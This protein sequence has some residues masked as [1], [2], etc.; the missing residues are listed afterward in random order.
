MAFEP[1]WREKEL[2]LKEVAE[3]YPDFPKL[4]ALKIDASRRGIK[5][6]DRALAAVDPDFHHVEPRSVITDSGTKGANSVPLGVTLRDGTLICQGDKVIT[7]HT[8]REPYTL[9][10][11]DGRPVLIDLG[12]EIEGV[13]FWEKPLFYDKVTSNGTPMREVASARPQR[14][15]VIP[16]PVCEFWK[17]R[18]GCKYCSIFSDNMGLDAVKRSE[19]YF[20]DVYETV[21]EALKQKG[22][23]AS[24]MMTSGTALGGEELLDDEVDAYI[25]TLQA[26]GKAIGA[27]KFTVKLVGTAFSEKQ[28]RRLYDN[29]GITTYTTDLEVLN[30]D[31]FEWICPGKAKYIGYDE[32]KNRLYT[33]VGIFGKGNV[34]TGFVGGVE[35]AQP[36]GF[37]SEEE[38]LTSTL[39]EAEEIGAHGVSF[40]ETVWNANPR[41]VFYD[42]REPSLEYC[43]RLAQG[44]ADIRRKNGIGI[45]TD[46]Y[47]RCGNHPNTDLARI[48]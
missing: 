30:K 38:A 14:I 5:Y 37:K 41:S 10:I 6:T 23:Y 13:E 7:K 19:A 47:R 29:T 40:A 35:T 12:E 9:D 32:W 4:I 21:E 11:V 16:Q 36:H 45:Y 28:L 48:D 25:Q 17:H 22:R 8:R 39:A 42:Q 46:D 2:S 26:A 20:Q 43:V 31:L 44:L 3:K 18:C 24:F 27:Q 33:A 34:N 15:C 1:D